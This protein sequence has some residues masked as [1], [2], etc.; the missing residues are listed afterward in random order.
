MTNIFTNASLVADALSL[1]SHWIYDQDLIALK[2]PN[3]IKTFSNPLSSYHPNRRAGQLTHYGDQTAMLHGS[4][5]EGRAFEPEKW[6][7]DWTS[8]IANYDGYIDGASKATLAKEGREPSSSSDLAGASR[9]GPILDL[10]LSLSEAVDSARAQTTLTHG[11][12]DVADVAEFVV[13]SVNASAEGKNFIQSL[14]QA[15]LDG[16]YSNLNASATL[17]RASEAHSNDFRTVAKEFG[18]SCSVANAFPLTLYFSLNFSGNFM[19]TMS[20]NALAGGDTSARAM[21]LAILL[22][23]HLSAQDLKIIDELHAKVVSDFT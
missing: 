14:K 8:N 13:R 5:S 10:S 20:Q 17:Q 18:Q 1:G 22:T 12:P 4:I 23:P 9:I 16:N 19:E 3:G 2:F 7:I 11:D 6:R 21:I 15:A